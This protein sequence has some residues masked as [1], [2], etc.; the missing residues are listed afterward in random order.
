VR[1][2]DGHR[3]H[4]RLQR[5]QRRQLEGQRAYAGAGGDWHSPASNGKGASA[6]GHAPGTKLWVGSLPGDV[7]QQEVEKVFA[8]HGRVQEVT[9]MPV[10]SRSG[11]ACAFVHL[12]TPG[13]ADACLVA[14]QAGVEIRP[15]DGPIQ[16]ERPGSRKGEAPGGYSGGYGK[17]TG[18]PCGKM[19]GKSYDGKSYDG[20]SYG[21][22]YD[23][24]Y[25]KSCGKGG[26][27]YGKDYGKGGYYPY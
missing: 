1:R 27:D 11:Q 15:G 17:P 6:S 5:R 2:W 13:E 9:L 8:R 14:M 18:K 22:S 23:K 24:N 12:A 20:K 10:K 4:R 25:G 3:R 7:T 26:K 19:D 21:K 16:V